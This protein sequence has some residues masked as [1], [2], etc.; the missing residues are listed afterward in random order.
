L[1]FKNY[2]KQ[3]QIYKLYNDFV[4]MNKKMV[5]L[6]EEIVVMSKNFKA[7]EQINKDALNTNISLVNDLC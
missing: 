2:N 7:L 5:Y 1:I 3:N 6:K 4:Q